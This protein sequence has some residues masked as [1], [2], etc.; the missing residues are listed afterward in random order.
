MNFIF[1]V[2]IV[3]ASFCVICLIRRGFKNMVVMLK[4]EK[5]IYLK[6]RKSKNTTL[7]VLILAITIL[8]LTGCGTS[9]GLHG[10]KYVFH[11]PHNHFH[12]VNSNG[13]YK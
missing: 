12:S 13:L 10:S 1:A 7:K 9:N 11:Q 2:L 3:L 8:S 5:D 4:N 6:A